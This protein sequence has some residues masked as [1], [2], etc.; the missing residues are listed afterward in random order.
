MR[1]VPVRLGVF[2]AI[3][4]AAFFA[5]FAIGNLGSDDAEATV[6]I[7]APVRPT[8]SSDGYGVVIEDYALADGQPQYTVHIEHHGGM[9]VTDFS[10]ANGARVHAFVV[11]PDLSE[12]QHL[13]PAV[14]D[15][16]RIKVPVPARGPWHL[17]FTFVP[18]GGSAIT[19]AQEVT[20]SAP[21]DEQVLP[22]AAD[23]ATVGDLQVTRVGWRFTVTDTDGAT[24]A[25]LATYLGR[26]AHLVAFRDTDLAGSY[27][28]TEGGSLGDYDFGTGITSA[29]TYRV[30][31]QFGLDGDVVTIPMTVVVP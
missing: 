24:P 30:F 4:T 15:D 6:A 8:D 23:T 7:G 27:L 28:V 25:G 11:R 3:L 31:L 22:A 19:L 12:F 18:A 20:D 26:G 2:A 17:V 14:A 9:A 5:A 16:G 29:G 21:Y 10:A 1:S 13:T